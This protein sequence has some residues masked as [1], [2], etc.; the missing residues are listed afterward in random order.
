ME[1]AA[2]LKAAE[3]DD[4]DDFT[5]FDDSDDDADF[6]DADFD[7]DEDDDEVMTML[8]EAAKEADENYSRLETMLKY[9]ELTMHITLS[10]LIAFN[11]KPR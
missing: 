5:D 4:D 8:L 6:E 11:A 7:D 10:D 9:D 3:Q 2:R 1:E